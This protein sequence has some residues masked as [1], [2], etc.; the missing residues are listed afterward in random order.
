MCGTTWADA[1]HDTAA[2][3]VA[4]VDADAGD[5]VVVES[6]ALALDV[7]ADTATSPTLDD[8]DADEVTDGLGSEEMSCFPLHATVAAPP[9][10][11]DAP[12][13]S[14]ARTV[15]NAQ[16]RVQEASGLSFRGARAN[17]LARDVFRRMARRLVPCTFNMTRP[18]DSRT[19]KTSSLRCIAR[20]RV[21]SFAR[22]G[23][24]RAR[25]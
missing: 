25:P 12:T 15:G 20:R 10:R 1:E 7:G 23:D 8:A 21:F 17:G 18:I 22:S 3:A 24:P 5:A 4:E 11:S 2:I 16:G 14:N 13:A 6:P 9:A 19:R